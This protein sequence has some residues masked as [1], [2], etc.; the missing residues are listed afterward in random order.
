MEKDELGKDHLTKGLIRKRPIWK[1]DLVVNSQIGKGPNAS[2]RNGKGPNGRGWSG[3]IRCRLQGHHQHTRS[4]WTW[5]IWKTSD[6]QLT[7]HT[8]DQSLKSDWTQSDPQNT[9]FWSTTLKITL[10]IFS[11]LKSTEL[12]LKK[13]LT[14]KTTLIFTLKYF[15]LLFKDTEIRLKNFKSHW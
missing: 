10:K 7:C 3:M 15:P 5:E 1:E 9:K 12:T 13:T 11:T 4:Y 14:K 6:L 2:G 8:K